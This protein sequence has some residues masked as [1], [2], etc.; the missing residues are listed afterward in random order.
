[1]KAGSMDRRSTAKAILGLFAGVML[2]VGMPVME[3]RSAYAAGQ[4]L[5]DALQPETVQ[6]VSEMPEELRSHF[7][8]MQERLLEEAPVQEPL[9]PE[10]QV[11]EKEPPSEDG[12]AEACEA[13]EPVAAAEAEAALEES[14][15]EAVRE[16][17]ASEEGSLPEA[18]GEADPIE[19]VGGSSIVTFSAG[20]GITGAWSPDSA[21]LQF[22][23]RGCSQK[24]ALSDS[25]SAPWK[26]YQAKAKKII[27]NDGVTEISPRAFYQFYNVKE[28]PV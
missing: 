24:G 21:T 8:K 23:Y 16:A 27:I 3:G 6:K 2:F 11:S 12:A 15:D 7:E 25:S 13:E 19:A 26:A 9:P 20:N 4:D 5:S 17:E 28:L 22:S 14:L 1:M 10:A 18:A